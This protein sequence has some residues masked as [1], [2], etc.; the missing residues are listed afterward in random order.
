[1]PRT[2][3]KRWSRLYKTRKSFHHKSRFWPLMDVDCIPTGHFRNTTSK[4]KALLNWD[5]SNKVIK[6][7]KERN[8]QWLVNH[9]MLD[10]Y[11][12]DFEIGYSDP[13]RNLRYV[14]FITW[15][16]SSDYTN[17]FPNSHEINSNWLHHFKYINYG[18]HK[19]FF[20]NL[21]S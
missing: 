7:R 20:Y 12:F 11:H 9:I 18:C 16:L 8:I 10:C 14:Y 2:T 19:L 4:T 1:M 6:Y 3:L 21:L 17:F 13:L 5:A 15:K